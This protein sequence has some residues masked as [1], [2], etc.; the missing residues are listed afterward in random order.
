MD[1]R[2]YRQ[3]MHAVVRAT[4]AKFGADSIATVTALCQGQH[5]PS[6]SPEA[7]KVLGLLD[8]EGVGAHPELQQLLRSLLSTTS[9]QDQPTPPALT[10][11][12]QPTPPALT[13]QDQPAPPTLTSQDQPA[14]PA[15]TS[16]DQPVPPAP[17]IQRRESHVP[18]DP[19]ELQA[20]NQRWYDTLTVQLQKRSEHRER[21]WQAA[22]TPMPLDQFPLDSLLHKVP[23]EELYGP[24]TPTI[25]KYGAKRAR[26]REN[27]KNVV[28]C[29]LAR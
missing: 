6:G 9:S 19:L 24:N 14:P 12:D 21:E 25:F 1:K 28:L 7:V 4:Q 27:D 29:K 17:T 26:V 3:L 5:V 15:V 16:Q 2:K 22:R 23:T 18:T 8:L 11:Q 10:L 13:S 20:W